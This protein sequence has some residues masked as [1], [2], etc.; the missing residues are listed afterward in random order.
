MSI[1]EIVKGLKV[2]PFATEGEISTSP[3][4]PL[5]PVFVFLTPNRPLPLYL[6][7]LVHPV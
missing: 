2:R 1:N 6:V 7:N 5:S 3:F 4:N